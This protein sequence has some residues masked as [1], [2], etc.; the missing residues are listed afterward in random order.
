[1]VRSLSAT[2]ESMAFASGRPEVADNR[3]S[4]RRNSRMER[5]NRKFSSDSLARA[6]ANQFQLTAVSGDILFGATRLPPTDEEEQAFLPP[7]DEH[8]PKA[9]I[10]VTS[11]NSTNLGQ[12]ANASPTAGLLH[13]G[14]APSTDYAAIGPRGGLV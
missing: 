9:K 13:A 5:R 11:V 12:F 1:M 3:R 4:S 8:D 14:Q 6:N 2:S 10:S 7:H